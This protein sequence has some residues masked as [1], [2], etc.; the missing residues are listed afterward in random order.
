MQESP[1]FMRGERQIVQKNIKFK[2]RHSNTKNREERPGCFTGNCGCPTAQALRN[3]L[4]QG[5]MQT[6]IYTKHDGV[7]DWKYCIS[8]APET[9]FEVSGTHV[10]LA[11]NPSVYRLTAQ[12]LSQA[13]KVRAA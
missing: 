3:D 6:A 12:R 13:S 11:F 9:N 7:V 8:D 4:P 1:A 2:S 5:I 10:G